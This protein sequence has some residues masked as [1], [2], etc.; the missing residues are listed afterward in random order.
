MREFFPSLDMGGNQALSQPSIT[1]YPVF[2]TI[3][4]TISYLYPVE[5]AFE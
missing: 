3:Y 5:L 1:Q 4:Y 2:L